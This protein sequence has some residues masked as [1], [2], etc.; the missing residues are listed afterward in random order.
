M[1]EGQNCESHSSHSV[2]PTGASEMFSQVF[3]L[4]FVCLFF[5]FAAEAERGGKISARSK[6]IVSYMRASKNKKK[7]IDCSGAPSFIIDVIDLLASNIGWKVQENLSRVYKY[8]KFRFQ[9]TTKNNSFLP[10]FLYLK[11]LQIVKYSSLLL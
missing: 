2:L 1:R 9:Q 11:A 3:C 7:C 6:R 4:C 10:F 5:C 8:S